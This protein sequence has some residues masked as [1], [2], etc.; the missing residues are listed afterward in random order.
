MTEVAI[1]TM[2]EDEREAVIAILAQWNMA[3]V[4]VS[5]DLPDPETTGLVADGT[6]FVA[7]A[8]DRIIGV[9][10]F[11]EHAGPRAETVSLAVDRG[12]RGAGVGAQLQRARLQEMK[13]RGITQV[14]T[15]TD[16]PEVVQWYLRK[17]GYRTVGKRRK[18]HAFSLPNVDHWT[19]LELNLHSW[20]PH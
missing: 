8:G 5:P 11:I 3:P 17:F 19:V 2:R 20:T 9:A 12:W 13:S 15:E 18:K 4:P 1:R 7:V 14:L 16:R 10:S 6:T